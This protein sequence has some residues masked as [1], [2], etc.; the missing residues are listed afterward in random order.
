MYNLYYI[1]LSR[2]FVFEKSSMALEI[3]NSDFNFFRTKK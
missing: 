3:D 2:T 1:Q